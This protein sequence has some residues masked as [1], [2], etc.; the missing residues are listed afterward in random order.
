[1]AASQL[2]GVSPRIG[3]GAFAAADYINPT[4]NAWNKGNKADAAGT[5]A[6]GAAET[7]FAV[8]F[9][10]LYA[11]AKIAQQVLKPTSTSAT[12]TTP[13]PQLLAKTGLSD[14]AARADYEKTYGKVGY[15]PAH[16]SIVL[17]NGAPTPIQHQQNKQML[18]DPNLLNPT[19]IKQQQ[20][21]ITRPAEYTSTDRIRDLAGIG[22]K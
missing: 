10:E 8:A 15:D 12:D 5:A 1:M 18:S 19:R 9:P 14:P 7:G 6:M 2:P 13:L 3:A 17:P 16:G 20:Q 21:N 22:R 4:I 11:P